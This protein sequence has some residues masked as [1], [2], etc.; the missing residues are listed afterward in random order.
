M[1]TFECD[2][3]F[4]LDENVLRLYSSDVYG[5]SLLLLYL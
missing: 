4:I 3:F 5:L 1:H 2:I